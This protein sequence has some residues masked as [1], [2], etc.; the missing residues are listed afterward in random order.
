MSATVVPPRS[1]ISQNSMPFT[2]TSGASVSSSAIT[3]PH[4]A[5][6]T[7]PVSRS[8]VVVHG[9]RSA[10]VRA[11]PNTMSVE[12]RAPPSAAGV[13]SAADAGEHR[14]ERAD[15]GAAR[16]AE[17]VRIGERIAQER[18]HQRAGQ[19]EQ[20]ADGERRQRARQPQLAHDGGVG[21]GVAR[22]T[23]ARKIAAPSS[24]TLPTASAR[25]SAA[26]AA[27]PSAARTTMW[28]PGVTR[29]KCGRCAHDA[30]TIIR[31]PP[32]RTRDPETTRARGRQ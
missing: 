22:L 21:F 27:A 25:A 17:N 5:A 18:L 28:R 31:F 4:P 12:A 23:S 10:P 11:S 30:A 1:P 14:P 24:A 20:P 19:C 7:T 29:M 6:T 26:S 16:N 15:G 32:H 8:R 2:C 13:T 9:A 3:A